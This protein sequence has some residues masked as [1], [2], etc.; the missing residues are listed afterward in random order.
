MSV[1]NYM[2]AEGTKE[3]IAKI[4]AYVASATSAAKSEAVEEAQSSFDLFKVV[5]ALPTSDISTNK[6]YLLPAENTEEGNLYA[7]YVYTGEKWE[8]LG[9]MEVGVDLSPYC[10]IEHAQELVDAL[11]NTVSALLADYAK[12][13]D[14]DDYVLEADLEAITAEEVDS[15]WEDVATTSLAAKVAA[16]R[17]AKEAADETADDTQ[18]QEQEDNTAAEDEGEEEELGADDTGDLSDVFGTAQPGDTEE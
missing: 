18:E 15:M 13:D 3:L 16:A 9:E 5:T 8:K 14:L 10:T 1:I 2:G 4:K 6:I 17:A 7:E 11:E 12:K